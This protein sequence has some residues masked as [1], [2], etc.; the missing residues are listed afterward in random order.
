MDLV[1]TDVGTLNPFHLDAGIVEHVALS[2]QFL[3]PG[4]IENY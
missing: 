1:R 3:G 4:G 2:D